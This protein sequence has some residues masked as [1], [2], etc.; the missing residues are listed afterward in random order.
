MAVRSGRDHSATVALALIDRHVSSVGEYFEIKRVI[1]RYLTERCARV[2][3]LTVNALDDPQAT[4]EQGLY[5]TVTG[6]SAEMGDDGQVGCGNRVNGLITPGRP[7]S[8]E[9]AAGKNPVGHVGKIYNVLANV[10]AQQVCDDIAE[11]VEASVQLVS[12]IGQPLGQPWM[13]VVEV[14]PVYR[15]TKSI[16]ARIEAIVTARL[17]AV[18][19]LVK[20]LIDNDIKVY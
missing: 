10:I 8:L 14:T 15:L 18:D 4:A 17:G 20:Q 12:R 6:L 13:A 19:G 9:A 2:A 11:V 7:M 1:H 5:L 3:A 16:R